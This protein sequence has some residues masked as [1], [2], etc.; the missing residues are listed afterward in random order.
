M[1]KDHPNIKTAV[2]CVDND[3]AGHKAINRIRPKLEQI[4]IACETDLSVLKDW[5]M[6][7]TATEEPVETSGITQSM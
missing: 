1:I 3:E 6:D 4:G 7:L 5:N 2:L